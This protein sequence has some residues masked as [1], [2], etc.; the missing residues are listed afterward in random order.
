[1]ASN[2]KGD[3]LASACKA[4]TSEHAAIYLW[5]TKSW[6]NFDKLVGHSLTVVQMSFSPCDRY[7]LSVSRDRTWCL[8]TLDDTGQWSLKCKTDKKTSGH[9]RIIWSC[10]WS[11]DSKYFATAGRDKRIVLWSTETRTSAS[12]NPLVLED[13]VTA[14]AFAPLPSRTVLVAGLDNGKILFVE[15]DRDGDQE[16]RVL[17]HLD[18]SVA[19]HKTVR[20]LKFK[21]NSLTLASC[22]ADHH[23][24]LY[25]CDFL[26]S[27]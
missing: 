27:S 16:W 3:I 12:K 15:H 2:H 4:T 9:Q 7:L 17:K 26:N 10:D 24:K 1:M 21:P 19:H 20:R 5:D 13:S 23:V 8:W 18:N 14:I 22:S 11:Q 25:N 6:K